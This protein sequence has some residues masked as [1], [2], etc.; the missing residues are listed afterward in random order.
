M[1]ITIEMPAR[2]EEATPAEWR[3]YL[4]QALREPNAVRRRRIAERWAC[5]WDTDASLIG[6]SDRVFGL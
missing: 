1:G 2:P 4:R 5:R 3:E 6:V